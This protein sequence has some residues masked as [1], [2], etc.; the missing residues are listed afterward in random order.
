MVKNVSIFFPELLLK[1]KHWVVYGQSANI[2]MFKKMDIFN[3]IALNVTI[4]LID[5]LIL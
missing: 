1:F 4:F 3:I 2:Y 5:G